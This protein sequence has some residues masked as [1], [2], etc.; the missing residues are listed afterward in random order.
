MHEYVWKALGMSPEGTTYFRSHQRCHGFVIIEVVRFS[1]NKLSSQLRKLL[2]ALLSGISSQPAPDFG[3]G[4]VP[5]QKGAP[6]MFI[7]LTICATCAC[8]LILFIE[9][10][11][12]VCV[13]NHIGQADSSTSLKYY[14]ILWPNK[15][16]LVSWQ[17]VRYLNLVNARPSHVERISL[18]LYSFLVDFASALLSFAK[19]A[20]E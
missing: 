17:S 3:G 10:S 15:H 6:T 4:R 11:L 16:L 2:D 13:I 19:V 8:Q 7:C 9:E 5:H 18:R 12:F 14:L 20:Y 1:R